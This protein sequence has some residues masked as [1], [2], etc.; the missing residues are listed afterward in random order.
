MI[1][2]SICNSP[3]PLLPYCSGFCARHIRTEQRRRAVRPHYRAVSISYGGRS[4]IFI[5]PEG[6]TEGFGV[7]YGIRMLSR[8]FECIR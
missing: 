2:G 3:P 8:E 7:Y 4:A 6:F 5:L 1:L